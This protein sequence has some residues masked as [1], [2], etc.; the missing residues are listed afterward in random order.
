MQ[1]AEAVMYLVATLGL[2]LGYYTGDVLAAV[3]QHHKKH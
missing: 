3:I 1:R 2:A